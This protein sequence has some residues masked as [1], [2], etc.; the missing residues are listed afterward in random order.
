[1]KRINELRTDLAQRTKRGLPFVIASLILWILVF[2]VWCLPL[3][4]TPWRN[5]LSLFC[6]LSPMLS[7]FLVAKVMRVEFWPKKNPL[8]GLVILLT[9]NPI[10]DLP[11]VLGAWSAPPGTI[12]RILAV[13]CGAR[14]LPFYWLYHSRSYLIMSILIP[15][16]VLGIS[17]NL[18]ERK[19]FLLAATMIVL[20]AV[21]LT[22]LSMENRREDQLKVGGVRSLEDYFNR[23]EKL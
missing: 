14:L 9:L 3:S 11:L 1:M 4:S 6:A 17:W 10:L 21:L 12:V 18:P 19:V 2:L 23:E 8:R 20:K 7:V 22:W 16:T 5:L 13:L 15:L